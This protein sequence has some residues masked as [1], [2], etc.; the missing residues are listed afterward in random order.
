MLDLRLL[1]LPRRN[2]R[3]LAFEIAGEIE[4]REQ[5]LRQHV[6]ITRLNSKS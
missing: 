1:E 5:L 4:K 3:E 6:L 2:S